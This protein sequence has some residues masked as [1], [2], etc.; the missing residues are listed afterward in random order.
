VASEEE[1]MNQSDFKCLSHCESNIYEKENLFS[2]AH[3]LYKQI[4]DIVLLNE[5]KTFHE[6][7]ETLSFLI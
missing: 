6:S 5:K 1:R 2:N 3:T 4:T 7:S